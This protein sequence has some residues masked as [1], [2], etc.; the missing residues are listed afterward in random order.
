MQEKTAKIG[1]VRFKKEVQIS[2]LKNLFKFVV[3]LTKN[4]I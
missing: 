3:I 2:T 4:K 1:L